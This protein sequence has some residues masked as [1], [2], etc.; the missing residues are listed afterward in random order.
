[1]S[2]RAYDAVLCDIDGVLRI[3]PP[4]DDIEHENR[5]APGTLAA[6]AFAPERLVPAITGEVTDEHWR[7]ATATAV[8]EVCGSA[9]RARAAVA[10]WSRLEPE[11]DAEAVTLL[12]AARVLVPIALVSNGTTRLERDLAR[13]GLHDVADALIN[14]ARIGF[15]K[16]DPRVYRIASERVGVPLH[17]CL[18]VD[19]S[20]PNVTAARELGMPAVHFRTIADLRDALG[21]LPALP[22][23]SSPTF[24]HAARSA[25]RILPAI[26]TTA[27]LG[28]P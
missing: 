27:G 6:I 11:V 21:P 10:T 8:A 16:P 1:M 17:R 24:S 12:R 18:F 9:E 13:Q 5:L 7:A 15:I 22:E 14:T 4:A 19:D 26:A 23:T 2:A 3:W 25:S 28:V 20:E